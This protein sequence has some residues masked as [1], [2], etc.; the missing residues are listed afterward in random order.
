MNLYRAVYTAEARDRGWAV[1]YA[2]RGAAFEVL[3]GAYDTEADALRHI[4]VFARLEKQAGRA[5][6]AARNGVQVPDAQVL[7]FR[8]R[9]TT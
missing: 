2:S 8:R 3:V 9:V 7:P 4:L 5:I 1:E 6:C